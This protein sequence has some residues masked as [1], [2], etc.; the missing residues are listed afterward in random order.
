MSDGRMPMRSSS[1]SCAASLFF[2]AIL[3]ESDMEA[4]RPPTGSSSGSPSI[5]LVAMVVVLFVTLIGGTVTVT[6]MVMEIRRELA[7]INMTHPHNHSKVHQSS[8][9]LTPKFE[10][11]KT[12]TIL[13]ELHP[14]QSGVTYNADNGK[15]QVE[16]NGT[17][18]M[19]LNLGVRCNPHNY[20][21]RA[22]LTIRVKDQTKTQLTCEV[23][24]PAGAKTVWAND[25][26]SVV[27]LSAQQP[28]MA[29]M[30]TT[31]ENEEWKLI[32]EHSKLGLLPVDKLGK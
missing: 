22:T 28:L 30:I 23:K 6:L 4:L 21:S 11:V 29:E 25:C 9:I 15:I 32:R 24:L 17:Y 27:P 8:S 18:L 26:L 3:E 20:C 13:W 1:L 16:H 10:Q 14:G 2:W 7:E 5:W 19:Y 31:V 12:T